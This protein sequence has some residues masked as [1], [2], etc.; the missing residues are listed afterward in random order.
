MKYIILF[1]GLLMCALIQAQTFTGKVISEGEKGEESLVGAQLIWQ[2]SQSGTVTDVEGN[3]KFED[4]SELPD[5]LLVQFV[6]FQTL[7]IYFDK[8]PEKGLKIKMKAGTEIQAVVVSAGDDKLLSFMDPI[9]F[10]K[11]N[12]SELKKAACCNLSEAFETNAS[13]DVSIADA[14]SGAKKIQMLGL[15]GVYTQMQ[16]ENIPIVRGLSSSY[17]LGTVP[18]TWIESIQI[19]KGRGSVVNG[20]EAMAGLINLEYLKPDEEGPLF[21]NVYGNIFGRAEL[22][23]HSAFQMGKEKKWS[24]LFLVHGSGLFAENDRNGDGFMDLPKSYQVNVFNR[25]KYFGEKFRTQFGGKFMYDE[26]IGGQLGYSPSQDKGLWGLNMRTT[27]ADLFAKTGFLLNRQSAS[28]GLIFQGKFHEFKSVFGT[29]PFYGRERK[30]Y[31]NSIYSDEFK[32][33]DHKIKSGFSFTYN[34]FDQSYNDSVFSRL[35]LVPGAYFEY[36]YSLKEKFS[37]VAGIRGDYHNLY[38]IFFSPALHLKWN[39]SKTTVLRL[40]SGHGYRVPNAYADNMSKLV[41]ARQWIITES[42]RPEQALTSGVTFIQKFKIGG[43]ES[44]FSADY[45]YTHFFNQMILDMDQNPQFIFVSNLNGQSFSHAVQGELNLEV[46]RGFTIRLA[47]KYYDVRMKTNNQL[48][49]KAMVPK[50]RGLLNLGYKTRNKKWLFDVTANWVGVKRLPGTSSNPI[51]YQR[52]NESKNFV[53]L[54]AQI[55]Y[56][57]KAW[58]FYIGGENLTNYIQKDAIVASDQPFSQYFDAS[59]VWAPVAG[60]NVYGGIRFTIKKKIKN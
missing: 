48:Q 59:M 13:V 2:K 26:K 46:A 51:E 23:L 50:H 19:T 29:V 44:S 45:F 15:D 43:R 39:L 49:Q 54:N 34:Q 1:I 53:L 35:E 16:F 12:Q 25:Y 36:I 37:L 41:S 17:G 20:Y 55:T 28:F 14:V 9:G 4:V 27:H 60:V 52:P 5:T 58:E 10:E 11:I 38:G 3:F 6:G 22:N 21:V 24:S 7:K 8:I 56:V 47:Y 57:H 32:N 18:G 31:F 30:A 40:S 42:L 33:G